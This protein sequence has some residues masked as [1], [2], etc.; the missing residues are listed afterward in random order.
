MPV[1][2]TYN[3]NLK[4]MTIY[5]QGYATVEEA[6]QCMD[7]LFNSTEIPADANSLWDV[8][9]QKFDHI[10]M[11]FIKRLVA[12]RKKH[13]DKRGGAK[14]AILSNFVLAA[15]LI[16]L[17]T[18]LSKNLKQQTKAFKVFAEAEQWLCEE[19]LEKID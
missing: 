2:L 4:Y 19:I 17:Y 12:L 5:T 14:I 16:K 1:T 3:K 10:D 11:A 15:P 13:D 9:E 18:I 6:E 8:R 7:E